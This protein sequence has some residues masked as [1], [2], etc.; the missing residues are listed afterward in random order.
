MAGRTIRIRDEFDLA[1]PEGLR[2]PPAGNRQGGDPGG[3]RR[4]N[5]VELTLA[6]ALIVVCGLIGTLIGATIEQAIKARREAA[7]PQ[8]AE[9]KTGRLPTADELLA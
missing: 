3:D 2:S 1:E 6:I 8:T 5:T 4:G 7:E 9:A